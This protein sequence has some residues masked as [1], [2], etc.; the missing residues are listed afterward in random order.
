MREK[1]QA[2]RCGGGGLDSLESAPSLGKERFSAQPAGEKKKGPP[3]RRKGGGKSEEKQRSFEKAVDHR[4]TFSSKKNVG[5]ESRSHSFPR[6]GRGED[7]DR[8]WRPKECGAQQNLDEKKKR[9]ESS[10]AEGKTIHGEGVSA[11]ER[12]LGWR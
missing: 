12:V 6:L 1:E 4:S 9:G 2:D 3:R 8:R 11:R 10:G 7:R 5:N